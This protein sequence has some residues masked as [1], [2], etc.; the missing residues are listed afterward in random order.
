MRRASGSRIRAGLAIGLVGL[1]VWPRVALAQP[2]SFDD[3]NDAR[4]PLDIS[5]VRSS[6]ESTP[7][8]WTIR[9]FRAWTARKIW[10]RGFFV[11]S[12]DTLGS[13]D[14]DYLA[15][16]RSNGKE[17][18]GVLLRRHTNGEEVPLHPLDV[19]RAGTIG[20]GIAVPRRALRFGSSRTSFSWSVASTFTGDR[21]HTTCIDL[22]P[23]T[24]AVEQPL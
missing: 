21:C 2:G 9:T 1:A 19:W 20:A 6:L 8:T 10:D 18:E 22:A 11:V 13:A 5:S 17:L 23:D 7:L 12:L 16:I 4:G 3:P 14:P 24:G 15:L